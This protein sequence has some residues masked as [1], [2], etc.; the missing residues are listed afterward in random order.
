MPSPT[1]PVRLTSGNVSLVPL[2][3]C[4]NSQFSSSPSSSSSSSTSS[5]TS[6]PPPV[7][8]DAAA[9]D[10][11]V[12]GRAVVS[13]VAPGKAGTR[14]DLQQNNNNNNNNNDDDDDGGG[15]GG[16]GGGDNVNNVRVRACVSSH[17]ATKT[18]TK[19]V[20]KEGD[21]RARKTHKKKAAQKRILRQ[22]TWRTRR[23]VLHTARAS[24]ALAARRRRAGWLP[25]WWW[26]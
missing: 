20:I 14:D 19:T 24:P 5:D 8:A 17:A 16:G 12:I 21:V 7:T 26:L 2:H 15:G 4:S 1:P 10:D 3:D 11:D 22:R 9:N 13:A 23:A 18:T 6:P 25:A